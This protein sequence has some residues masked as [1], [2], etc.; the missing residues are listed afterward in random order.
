MAFPHR[1][2]GYVYLSLAMI[3]V[4]STVVASKIIGAAMPPFT[5]TAL[6]FAISSPVFMLLL[7]WTGEPWPTFKGRDLLLVLVQAAAGSVGYTVLMILGLRFTPA[8]DAGVVAGILPVVATAMSVLLL[9]ERADARCLISIGLAMTGLLAI[10]LQVRDGS[11]APP[12]GRTL[13]G[14]VLVLGAVVCEAL[15]LLLNR[16]LR[17]PASPLALSALMS[18]LGL[19]I[20]IAPA[21]A[22]LSRRAM[23]PIPPAALLGVAYYALG[24]TVL[25]FTLWY[26]GA[27]RT[28]GADAALFTAL[29]PVSA[30]VLAHLVLREVIRPQQALGTALVMGAI[31]VGVLRR[32]TASTDVEAT[33]AR[34]VN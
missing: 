9:G 24:P 22:E 6:R 18:L 32:R 3:G 7:R 20:S 31:A 12:S 29:L 26:K 21:A 11:M 19:A 1:A 16:K 27:Q 13:I 28:S 30:L 2:S 23:T 8:G 4:G 5:A 14:D 25:G 33:R 34:A 15:F 10:T 17:S